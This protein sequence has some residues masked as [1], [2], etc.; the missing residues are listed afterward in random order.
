MCPHGVVKIHHIEI[1]VDKTH[2]NVYYNY[3]AEVNV[4]Y[5]SQRKA[6]LEVLVAKKFKQVVLVENEKEK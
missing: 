6:L 4:T 2:F 5:K 3:N 1:A